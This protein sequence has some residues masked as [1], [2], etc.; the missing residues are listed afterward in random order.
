MQQPEQLLAAQSQ[1]STHTPLRQDSD[2]PHSWQGMP[3]VPQAPASLP[4]LQVFPSQQPSGQLL[5]S[6]PTL[7]VPPMHWVPPVHC[8][9]KTPLRPQD[10]S[11]W[12]GL[13][14]SPSQQPMQEV[15][16]QVHLPLT[17]A[18]LEPQ[19]LQALPPL[20]QLAPMLPGTQLP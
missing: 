4:G 9:Q 15:V 18:W 3:E 8:W 13:Q 17:Q 16:V 12:P 2:L 14:K 20:P 7:Q 1:E 6:Q 19:M 11:R 5:Q 10:V